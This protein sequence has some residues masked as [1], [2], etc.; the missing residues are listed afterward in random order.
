MRGGALHNP[1]PASRAPFSSAQAPDSEV[2]ASLPKQGQKE[3]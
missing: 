3:H 2:Q 1:A